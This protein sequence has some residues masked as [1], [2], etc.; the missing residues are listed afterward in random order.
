MYISKI[1]HLTTAVKP[2]F[3]R[4]LTIQQA[5]DNIEHTHTSFLHGAIYLDYICCSDW[6]MK[7]LT[8]SVSLAVNLWFMR[9]E[10]CGYLG[11]RAL[12]RAHHHAS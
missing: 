7:M 8:T 4:L 6:L 1:Q 5:I 12:A 3:S 9:I 2:P 11:T 10:V